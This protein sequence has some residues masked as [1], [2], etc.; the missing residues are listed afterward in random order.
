MVIEVPGIVITIPRESYRL[1]EK[2]N[3]GASKLSPNLPVDRTSA[4]RQGVL[5]ISRMANR[6]WQFLTLS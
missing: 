5:V 4:V 6:E 2:R 3:S 1:N